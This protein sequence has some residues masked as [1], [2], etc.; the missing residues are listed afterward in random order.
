LGVGPRHVPDGTEKEDPRFVRFGGFKTPEQ[1][2]GTLETIEVLAHLV[3]EGRFPL[4]V[5]DRCAYCDYRTACRRHHPPT[6]H[7]ERVSPDAEDARRCW[8]KKAETPLL[9]QVSPRMA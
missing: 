7:R 2:D 4:R 5:D 9:A 3:A 6:E 8:E 1:R